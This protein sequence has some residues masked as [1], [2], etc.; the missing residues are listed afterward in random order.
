MG[1]QEVVGVADLVEAEQLGRLLREMRLV[2]GV[3][4]R[5]SFPGGGLKEEQRGPAAGDGQGHARG[6]IPRTARHHHHRRAASGVADRKGETVAVTAAG[7]E[8]RE[9]PA[10]ALGGM[11]E[12]AR[13]VEHLEAHGVGGG[14]RRR[15][16]RQKA[17][18][19]GHERS[20]L[21]EGRPRSRVLRRPEQVGAKHRLGDLQLAEQELLEGPP[22]ADLAAYGAET[23]DPA[24]PVLLRRAFEVAE[25][26][27]PTE[28]LERRVPLLAR[29]VE[30][31]KLR[32]SAR[33]T[34][35]RDA[36]VG[37][38]VAHHPAFRPGLAEAVVPVHEMIAPHPGLDPLLLEVAL[39]L[40]DVP[41]VELARVLAPATRAEGTRAPLVVA[42]VHAPRLED[43]DDLVHQVEEDAVRLGVRRAVRV[44]P[45][46]VGVFRHVAPRGGDVV[47]V[48]ERLH[49]G[50]DLEAVVGRPL[51][52]P[53]HLVLLDVG[54]TSD[55]HVQRRR[56]AVRSAQ[57]DALSELV[58]GLAVGVPLGHGAAPAHGDLGMRVVPHPP[59][60]LQDE[61]VELLAQQEV[62]KVAAG[63]AEL[64]AP[65]KVQV[66]EAHGEERPVAN[67]G[68]A[69]GHALLAP[70]ADELDEGG[71]A[72]E[73]A[74]VVASGHHGSAVA[75]VERVP[76]GL[77]R[78]RDG[79]APHRRRHGLARDLAHDDR[80]L[81]QR[82]LVHRH[83]DHDAELIGDELREQTARELGAAIARGHHDHGIAQEKA[84]VSVLRLLG[85]GPDR[86]RNRARLF[87]ARR[88][89]DEQEEQSQ[90]PHSRTSNTASW[91]A[92][93]PATVSMTS[94]FTTC[95]PAAN[96][97]R[98]M[99]PMEATAMGVS[100]SWSSAFAT[101]F[102]SFETPKRARSEALPEA[103]SA[104]PP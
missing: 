91:V 95:R 1:G 97:A 37:T 20:D 33:Q 49:L 38:L 93:V 45:G 50:N 71:H 62:T 15:R 73:G 64:V 31:V 43:V 8:T 74:A 82:R 21:L 55:A 100:N 3:D 85:D 69:R 22:R 81:A 61:A 72:V 51:R 65:G 86:K 17:T 16:R 9:V 75:D 32:S 80:G 98:G 84:R 102:P 63:E 6:A 99:G 18:D 78:H 68:L 2:S 42:D 27:G 92:V 83:R 103:A 7:L 67:A 19:L 60:D 28:P 5:P 30:D 39:Y 34:I 58:H 76:L 87:P 52:E 29:P 10:L 25:Q 101:G 12:R 48:A 56:E 70:M 57:R 47:R 40:E 77:L 24:G 54:P 89:G 14:R 94:S 44:G 23:A 96:P 35:A 66:H 79:R 11:V 90:E 41:G 4:P 13:D 59:A 104:W 26:E 46:H 53:P 36:G 88:K